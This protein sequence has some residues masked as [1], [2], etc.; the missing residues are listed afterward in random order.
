MT[1]NLFKY[2]LWCI[3]F[4]MCVLSSIVKASDLL[5]DEEYGAGH[6]KRSVS[7]MKT[8]SKERTEVV[9]KRLK[10]TAETDEQDEVGV[11]ALVAGESALSRSVTI[12]PF[13]RS[14]TVYKRPVQSPVC[15]DSVSSDGKGSSLSVDVISTEA[16]VYIDR[17]ASIKRRAAEQE[18]AYQAAIASDEAATESGSDDVSISSS[19]TP[20]PQK[21]K[22]VQFNVSSLLVRQFTYDGK[23][24]PVKVPDYDRE[25]RD[26]R[27]QKRQEKS[28][29][30]AVASI[31]WL[32]YTDMNAHQRFQ[33]FNTEIC[34]IRDNLNKISTQ[35]VTD[36]QNEDVQAAVTDFVQSIDAL[37]TKALIKPLIQRYSRDRNSIVN[38]AECAQSMNEVCQAL[39]ED[40][41][42]CVNRL[43]QQGVC[44]DQIY[45]ESVDGLAYYNQ[46]KERLARVIPILM[47]EGEAA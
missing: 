8:R 10:P 42:E 24:N 13:Y 21:V 5:S 12:S 7:H 9:N 41:E 26:K 45:F 2:C 30:K 1:L 40:I 22:K 20:L 17:T 31:P 4:H 28:R 43:Q 39:A 34:K 47:H 14:E 37:N 19:D 44:F 25:Q 38:K 16:G 27:A 23:E 33:N 18:V 46:Q 6:K 29:Q 32:T 15:D 35:I 11:V 36:S 3:I